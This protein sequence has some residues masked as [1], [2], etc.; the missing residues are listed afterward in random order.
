VFNSVFDYSLPSDVKGDRIIDIRPQAGRNPADVFNQGYAQT[1]DKTKL[2]GLANQIYTQHNT[3]VKTIRIEAPT[4][5]SPVTITDTSSTQN[6]NTFG[7]ASNL[8]LDTT[9]NIAGG[10]ALQFDL[11]AGGITGFISN[12]LL[13][14]VDLTTQ[15][16]ISSLFA[17]IYLPK[18]SAISSIDVIYGD[19]TSNYY[20]NTVTTNQLGNSFENGNNLI[21]L[22][23]KSAIPVGN[24]TGVISY[25][26]FV[27]P[28]DG[29]LQTGVKICNLTSNLGS[30]FEIQYYSKFL[31]RNA[32][33]NAFQETIVDTTDNGKI[34]NLDTES[35]NLLFNKCAFFI[36][37]TLQ[38]ADA[39]YDADYWDT[40]Y[41][42]AL[43][44]YKAQNPSEAMKKS[45]VYY[46]TPNKGYSKFQPTV[47][48]R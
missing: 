27:F 30:I 8:S 34:I 2:L 39:Q 45:E 10:G 14:P 22:D 43:K 5:I 41:K 33:T 46:K 25:V 48:R 9:N 26:M 4:L 17:W 32:S 31:F 16:N 23:W 18:G 3:G 19:D 44:R 12:S 40:E 47:W 42:E 29:T 38:G 7:A 28:Y 37:Q 24:P 13:N 15:K 35:Y 1:F 36:A 21:Q 11:N 6:W 20:S